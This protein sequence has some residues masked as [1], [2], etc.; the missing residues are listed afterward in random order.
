MPSPAD[1]KNS[2]TLSTADSKNSNMSSAMM[3]NTVM[4]STASGNTLSTG[5]GYSRKLSLS[6][7]TAFSFQGLKNYQNCSL[8]EL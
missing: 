6:F 8:Q 2:N 4:I 5:D 1:S 7:L 3:A